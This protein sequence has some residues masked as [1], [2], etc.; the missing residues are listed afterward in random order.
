MSAQE[1]EAE[2]VSSCESA[3]TWRASA[4]SKLRSRSS[5]V[6]AIPASLFRTACMAFL[7]MHDHGSLRPELGLGL[8]ATGKSLVKSMG[9]SSAAYS[10]HSEISASL[11]P[12]SP[13]SPFTLGRLLRKTSST[14]WRNW[15]RMRSKLRE[16]LDSC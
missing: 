7:A 5:L 16:T 14:S 8:V 9:T 4:F 13:G 3:R 6:G 15:R 1:G 2:E 11:K 12:A 10:K